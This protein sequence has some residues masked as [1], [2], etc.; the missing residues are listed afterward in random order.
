MI[1]NIKR[2]SNLLIFTLLFYVWLTTPL[3]VLASN[4]TQETSANIIIAEV[5][6]ENKLEYYN[7]NIIQNDEEILKTT[8]SEEL[9]ERIN[10]C[11]VNT[12]VTNTV[13]SI[14]NSAENL[15]AEKERKEAE[16]EAERIKAEEE[17]KIAQEKAARSKAL[18]DYQ[19]DVFLLAAIIHCEARG[20]S[21][22]GQVAVGAVVL[23]RVNSSK[24][25]NT[26]KEVIYQSGQ[27]SPV[28]N[29]S[30]ERVLLDGKVNSSCLSAAQDALNGENPIGDCLYFRTINGTPGLEL[31]NHVFR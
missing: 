12:E 29:G 30:L 13:D 10:I 15:L 4:I 20:E 11:K 2:T 9:T 25:P 18:E 16:A 24:F 31:G 23:N 14:N 7:S 26:I 6:T 3:T 22:E 1:H 28:A 17:A 8:I 27:F 21:Y 19:D 5:E